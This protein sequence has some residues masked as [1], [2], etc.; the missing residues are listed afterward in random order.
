MQSEI[1]KFDQAND[2]VFSYCFEPIDETESTTEYLLTL[3]VNTA[4]VASESI[5]VS[6]EQEVHDHAEKMYQNYLEY[7][8]P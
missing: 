2:K 3:W 7:I 8:K 4:D 1:I 6:S 5:W